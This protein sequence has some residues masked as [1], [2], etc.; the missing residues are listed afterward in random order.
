M[1]YMFVESG[2]TQYHQSTFTAVEPV[3]EAKG[4]RCHPAK[5]PGP[6]SVLVAWRPG[7]CLATV[8]PLHGIIVAAK[9]VRRLVA[10]TVACTGGAA[11]A[12]GEL[13]RWVL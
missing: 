8:R 9:V 6:R 7:R 11:A 5:R 13:A 1:P 4:V 12:A 3:G 10:C 2:V